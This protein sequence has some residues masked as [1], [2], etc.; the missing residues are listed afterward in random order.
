MNYKAGKRTWLLMTL[1]YESERC[2]LWIPE[3]DAVV[4]RTRHH[5]STVR[6]HRDRQNFVLWE[7]K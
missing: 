6:C 3:V 7:I 1:K 2:I 5:P 4:H